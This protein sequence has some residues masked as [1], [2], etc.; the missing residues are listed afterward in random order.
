MQ[1]RSNGTCNV[2]TTSNVLD[3][4]LGESWNFRAGVSVQ[5]LIITESTVC[6]IIETLWTDTHIDVHSTP[7][8]FLFAV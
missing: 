4:V 8:C 7:Y 1:R 5:L 3:G 2:R 6:F